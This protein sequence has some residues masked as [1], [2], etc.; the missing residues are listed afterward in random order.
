MSNI[1]INI[2]TEKSAFFISISIFL[3]KRLEKKPL[4]YY[5]VEEAV[6]CAKNGHYATGI[7][8]FAQLLN[9][10]KEKTPNDRHLVAHQ[11]LEVRPTEKAYKEAK[12]KLEDVAKEISE[13]ETSRYSNIQEY[14]DKVHEEWQKL[15]KKLN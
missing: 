4:L 12:S 2:G 1:F 10:L 14:Q 8:T 13:M 5:A 11:I 6:L 9:L 15:M 3:I 7:L